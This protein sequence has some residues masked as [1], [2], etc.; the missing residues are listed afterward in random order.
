MKRH[1]TLT[2]LFVFYLGISG[3]IA[4]EATVTSGGDAQG[5]GGTTSYTVGQVAYT[6]I[7]ADGNIAQG[8]QQPYE[9]SAVAGVDESNIN[10]VFSTY[11]NPTTDYL[12]IEFAMI[13]ESGI[14][15]VLYDLNGKQLT[16][17]VINDASTKLDMKSFPAGS[18]LLSV[19]KNKQEVKSFKIIKY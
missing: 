8:V 7:G 2:G 13:P 4:Q 3:S 10:L 18:Y 19:K 16:G 9:I 11:P 12:I 14:S 1:L 15:Y 5:A 6:T 17:N